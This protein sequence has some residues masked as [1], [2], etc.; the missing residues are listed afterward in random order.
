MHNMNDKGGLPLAVMK[1]ITILQAQ[2][3]PIRTSILIEAQW[4]IN[5]LTALPAAFAH[6]NT[7]ARPGDTGKNVQVQV[8]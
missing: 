5:K 2:I 4:H 8:S 7:S 1:I 6:R 3:D